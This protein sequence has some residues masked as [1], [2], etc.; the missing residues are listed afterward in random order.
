MEETIEVRLGH[1]ELS[2]E[3]LLNLLRQLSRLR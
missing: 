1:V 2:E 3:S